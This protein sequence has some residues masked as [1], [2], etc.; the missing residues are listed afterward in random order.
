VW[1][2][3]KIRQA[4]LHEV[5]HVTGGGVNEIGLTEGLMSTQQLL[6]AAVVLYFYFAFFLMVLARKTSTSH[7]W[8]A[9]IP[10]ANIFL[11]CRI[12]RQSM[13]LGVLMIVPLV[14]FVVAGLLW[15]GIARAR[16]K[17]GWTGWLILVPGL[18]LLLP[19][20]FA[21]G[22]VTDPAA[23][24]SDPPAAAVEFPKFCPECGA[25]T[26]PDEQF[27]GEC[28]YDLH[29][30][31]DQA[32]DPPTPASSPAPALPGPQPAMVM[33]SPL[34]IAG[35]LTAI[36][37]VLFLGYAAYDSYSTPARSRQMPSMTPAMAGTLR[38]FPIDSA[39]MH[40]L[41]PDA[42]TAQMLNTI[43]VRVEPDSL[44]R[45][46]SPVTI[47]RHGQALT[48]AI[49][50]AHPGEPP[51]S[52]TVVTTSGDSGA[53]VQE[54]AREVSTAHGIAAS[55]IEVKSPGGE[56]YHGARIRDD[57]EA[58]YVLA[59]DNG[60]AV[61][62][63]HARD[64]SVLEAAERL[65]A[66]VGNGEGL[67][68]FPAIQNSLGT[69]PPELPADLVLQEA[70]TLT[71]EQL[72]DAESQ[73]AETALSMGAEA[74]RLA[75]QVHRVLPGGLVLARYHD[76]AKRDWGVMR[77]QYDSSPRALIAWTILRSLMTLTDSEAF[78]FQQ[79]EARLLKFG[80]RQV[81]LFRAGASIVLLAAPLD[82]NTDHLRQ[83]AGGAR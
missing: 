35:I 19:P 38:A 74:Q 48:Q 2:G 66:N 45:G 24:A 7:S 8:L 77:G 40:P 78:P 12:A 72:G 52:V 23:P 71:G 30:A 18:N 68:A 80:D 32:I 59:K 56:L 26:D 6:V 5:R 67:A 36:A 73:L 70:R 22:P 17:P 62:I 75:G 53:A 58:T 65:A 9:W 33:R 61:V 57:R 28:G 47:G 54:I 55:G 51:V 16:H 63:V 42:F 39:E 25:A 37:V 83:L 20:Y 15:S 13:L 76:A 34:A 60:G 43:P 49:Y 82:A 29:Q 4:L 10:I 64:S 31:I 27:C 41:Q 79:G 1:D 14:N 69:L 11:M 3:R 44:P 46:L 50:R 21:M 81:A